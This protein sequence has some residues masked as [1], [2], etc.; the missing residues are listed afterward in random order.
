MKKK[1]LACVMCGLFALAGTIDAKACTAIYVGKEAS[2]NGSAYIARS[3]DLEKDHNKIFKVVPAKDY[4]AGA[5]YVDP[6]GYTMHYPTHTLRHT[7]IMDD[8]E[9]EGVNGLYDYPEVGFNEKGVYVTATVS[10]KYHDAIQE[11]DPL[12]DTGIAEMSMA[13]VMLQEATSAK[14]AMEILAREVK[15]KGAAECNICLL[16]TS[17]CV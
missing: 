7:I 1:L 12:V 17:R 4:P 2:D 9:I 6:Y 14:H 11:K 5:T 15:T 3:E 13:E 16:Y 10:T 8:P